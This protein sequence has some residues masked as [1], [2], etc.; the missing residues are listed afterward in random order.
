M[1]TVEMDLLGHELCET[2]AAM[3][4]WLDERRFEPSVFWCNESG[5]GVRVRVD[6]KV[7]RE[8]QAFADRFGGRINRSQGR[9][10]FS[11][12]SSPR[13]PRLTA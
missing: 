7:V 4:I 13:P 3:R 12:V 9:D 8:A 11:A 6:F 1:R 2:M 5:M 10:G